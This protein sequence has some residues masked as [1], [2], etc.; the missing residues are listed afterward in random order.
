[1]RTRPSFATMLAA[2]NKQDRIT[3]LQAA[4]EH[5]I[6]ENRD[7]KTR[8]SE[9]EARFDSIIGLATDKVK[10]V[11]AKVTQV[12]SA[13]I[14]KVQTCVTTELCEHKSQEEN[15]LKIRIGGLPS[16]WCTPEDTLVVEAI[17]KL[18]VILQPINLKP[19]TVSWINDTHRHVPPEQG[20]LTFKD[21]EERAKLL[22]QSHLLKGTKIWITE[23]LTINQLKNKRTELLKMHEARKQ[24]KWAVY[25]GGKAII[26]EFQNP[27]QLP[28]P[29]SDSP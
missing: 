22:H 14:A 26:Q 25:R 24:G 17:I 9:L 5:V 4:L 29:R 28:P 3:Q 1:M 10:E 21:K 2:P 27:K 11:E 20:V 13:T 23:E 12:H 8:L 19:E 7:L 15:A 18:N 16:P 6:K